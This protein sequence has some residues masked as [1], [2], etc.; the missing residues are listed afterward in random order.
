MVYYEKV[1]FLTWSHLFC[2]HLNAQNPLLYALYFCSGASGK[3]AIIKYDVSSNQLTASTVFRPD[4]EAPQGS[5]VQATNGLFYG[6][7]RNGGA[8]N[9]GVIFSFNPYTNS[10]TNFM[11]LVVLMEPD[12]MDRLSRQTMVFYME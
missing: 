11:I 1:L 4:G 9:L 2:N 12:L 6:M 3:G 7:T 8:N 5:L 10:Y